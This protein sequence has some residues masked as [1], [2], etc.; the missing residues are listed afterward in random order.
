MFAEWNICHL[1]LCEGNPS[2]FDFS[3]KQSSDLL[4]A[5]MTSTD[6]YFI[7]ITDHSRDDWYSLDYIR[8]V[9]NNWEN[10]ITK[11]SEIPNVSDSST[12]K[13]TI[14]KARKANL[15][16]DIHI[17]GDSFYVKNAC[18]YST[19]GTDMKAMTT[20][21]QLNRFLEKK[22]VYY[23]H[24]DFYGFDIKRLCR[25]YDSNGT[26]FELIRYSD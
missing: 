10:L 5:I 1:H 6:A 17:D 19:A 20:L 18:G 7:D 3:R 24:L 23:D 21:I 26:W 15:N 2:I 9:K 11:N 22:S 14:I 8:I 4:M 25:V 12:D 16:S 13:E